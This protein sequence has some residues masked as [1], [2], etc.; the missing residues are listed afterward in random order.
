MTK[1]Y[2]GT[3]DLGDSAS[4][5]AGVDLS[6]VTSLRLGSY[7]CTRVPL[8]IG[9]A[10]FDALPDA[11]AAVRANCTDANRRAILLAWLGVLP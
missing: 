2:S 5:P 10:G 8:A 1:R 3:L 9:C 4:L 7:L 6:A 11:I